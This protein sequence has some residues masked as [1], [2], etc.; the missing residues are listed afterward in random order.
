MLRYLI[1]QRE[2]NWGDMF[3]KLED[4][5]SNFGDVIESYSITS[6][7]LEEVFLAVAEMDED[8]TNI[9]ARNQ[10]TCFQSCL[11]GQCCKD[12]YA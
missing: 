5:R 9:L 7:S 3:K 2:Q 12:D 11:L 10:T 4:I 6:S 1:P 8:S